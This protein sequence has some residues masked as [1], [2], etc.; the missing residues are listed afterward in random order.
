MNFEL[1]ELSF[2]FFELQS[3]VL[4]VKTLPDST[5]YL[6]TLAAKLKTIESGGYGWTGIKYDF[7]N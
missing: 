4:V 6:V 2:E 1:K 5:Q 3:W 7:G